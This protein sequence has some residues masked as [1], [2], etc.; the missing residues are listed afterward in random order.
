MGTPRFIG[1][2]RQYTRGMKVFR[3]HPSDVA[4]IEVEL[5]SIDIQRKTV[6]ILDAIYEKQQ[7]NTKLNSHLV[8]QGTDTAVTFSKASG[9]PYTPATAATAVTQACVGTVKVWDHFGTP[10]GSRQRKRSQA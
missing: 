4:R 2:L 1:E 5:P 9:C 6:A 8:K 3:V 10:W 7:L